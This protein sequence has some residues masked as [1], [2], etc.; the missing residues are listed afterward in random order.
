MHTAPSGSAALL[1]SICDNPW[2]SRPAGF[3]RAVEES[4]EELAGAGEPR[5]SDLPMLRFVTE[6]KVVRS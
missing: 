6:M 3:W 1:V 4:I 2:R 5:Q